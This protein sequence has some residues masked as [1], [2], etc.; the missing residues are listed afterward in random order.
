M[1]SSSGVDLAGISLLVV[2]MA[3]VLAL[4]LGVNLRDA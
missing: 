3:G 1:E 2:I 4:R